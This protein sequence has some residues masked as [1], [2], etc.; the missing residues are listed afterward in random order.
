MMTIRK[1]R[2][3][4]KWRKKRRRDRRRENNG[5]LLLT[6]IYNVPDVLHWIDSPCDAPFH[7][8]GN[9]GS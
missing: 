8:L 7:K 4:G 3:S 9:C 5:P 6:I 1:I 2:L